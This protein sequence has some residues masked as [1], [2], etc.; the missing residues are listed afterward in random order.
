M[1][2]L[3]KTDAMTDKVFEHYFATENIYNSGRFSKADF[4]AKSE[5]T[6]ADAVRIVAELL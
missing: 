4:P 2:L 6:L 5:L 3:I 1:A